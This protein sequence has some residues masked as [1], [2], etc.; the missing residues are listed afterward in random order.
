MSKLYPKI[1]RLRLKNL[2]HCTSVDLGTI[3]HK[4]GATPEERALGDA[5]IAE[6]NKYMDAFTPMVDGKC[7]CCG[8]VQ[9]VNPK[10]PASMIRTMMSGVQ[11]VYGLAHGEGYC[12]KCGWPGRA[13]HYIGDWCRFNIIMQ[14]HPE[15]LLLPDET[16]KIKSETTKNRRY[17][18]RLRKLGASK[19]EIAKALGIPEDA[20]VLQ[21]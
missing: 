19:F 6:L 21:E 12:S 4:E 7:I 3:T 13:N 8:G 9:G 11:F 17:V 20:P 18:K 2:P 15:S 1:R 5:R 14:Y 16:R 10:D